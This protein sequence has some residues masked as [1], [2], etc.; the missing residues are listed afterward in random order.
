MKHSH[1]KH[2]LS[3]PKCLYSL[4]ISYKKNLNLKEHRPSS[5]FYYISHHS[6]EV[7]TV[8]NQNDQFMQCSYSH[9]LKIQSR[10]RYHSLFITNA[11]KMHLKLRKWFVQL[12]DKVLWCKQFKLP[13]QLGV[14]QRSPTAYTSW[15]EYKQKRDEPSLS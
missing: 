14:I 15:E 7:P 5:R 11:K 4:S 13:E 6:V 3:L 1:P 2:Y 8:Q 9:N 10:K 12:W